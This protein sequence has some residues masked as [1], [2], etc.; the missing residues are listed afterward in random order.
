MSNDAQQ[1]TRSSW[2]RR[3]WEKRKDY[4]LFA[5]A[6][7]LPFGALGVELSTRLCAEFSGFDPLATPW[8]IAMV[9]FA[10]VT[11]LTLW[12]VVCG[13]VRVSA[14]GT[15][16]LA[17]GTGMALAFCALFTFLLF[18]YILAIFPLSQLWMFFLM[19]FVFLL[20]PF[21]AFSPLF[22]LISGCVLFRRL[23]GMAKQKG[24]FVAGNFC[25]GMAIGVVAVFMF[26]AM[27][28]D[29]VMI[30]DIIPEPSWK[31]DATGISDLLM[32]SEQGDGEATFRIALCHATGR[33]DMDK[34]TEKPIEGYVKAFRQGYSSASCFIG[35]HMRC[36]PNAEARGMHWCQR[37]VYRGDARFQF[38]EG[39]SFVTTDIPRAVKWLKK[40][41]E[42]GHPE[43]Q[44]LLERYTKNGTIISSDLKDV[45]DI[46]LMAFRQTVEEDDEQ[47]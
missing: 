2:I 28:V 46:V 34:N 45:H 37:I 3:L 14:I 18:N 40:S 29:A 41:A 22:A 19:A 16:L 25:V 8:H 9:A 44:L 7:L 39:Q 21:L 38:H 31:D 35:R 6:V 26:F 27:R 4:A 15:R 43:A 1:A 23:N 12:L 30:S 11:L 17:L 33:A 10:S 5:G 13:K 20:L 32:K 47:F 36:T 42:Q 24:L